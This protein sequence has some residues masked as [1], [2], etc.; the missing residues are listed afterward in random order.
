MQAHQW[1]NNHLATSRC[2]YRISVKVL[3]VL[4]RG[5]RCPRPGLSLRW[6]QITTTQ[7]L[8]KMDWEIPFIFRS[9]ANMQ[10]WYVPYVNYGRR[11]EKP[12]WTK[13]LRHHGAWRLQFRI[14]RNFTR[15][16]LQACFV[17][18]LKT[19]VQRSMG[20]LKVKTGNCNPNV[21]WFYIWLSNFATYFL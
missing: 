21:T 14:H 4:H 10:R 19:M 11:S 12:R 13:P 16:Y 8:V 20:I 9:S 5:S 15:W 17:R 1:S 18:I 2:V 7:K 6:K 3:R